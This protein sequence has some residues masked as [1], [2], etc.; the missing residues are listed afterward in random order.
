MRSAFLVVVWLSGAFF[1]ALACTVILE[2]PATTPVATLAGIAWGVVC[3][4]CHH[5]ST[6]S[7]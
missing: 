5:T 3:F 4:Y 2:P 6:S 7:A 1:I